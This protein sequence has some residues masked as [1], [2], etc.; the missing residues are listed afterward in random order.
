MLI[1][2]LALLVASVVT[3]EVFAKREAPIPVASVQMGELQFTAPHESGG[4][5]VPGYVEA[6]DVASDAVVWRRQIYTIVREPLIEGDI[7]DVF[8]T[9]LKVDTDRNVLNI[10]NENGDTF[11]LDLESLE[12]KAT[13]GSVVLRPGKR[14]RC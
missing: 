13:K 1:V 11:E 14:C 7:Q 2:G 3:K 9:T 12:V 6:R 5:Y 4:R 10:A 8:I